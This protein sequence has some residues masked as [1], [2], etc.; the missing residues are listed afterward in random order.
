M[1][2]IFHLFNRKSTDTQKVYDALTTEEGLTNW[3]SKAT[4]VEYRVGSEIKFWFPN[5][6]FMKT[7]II[8]LDQNKSVEWECIHGDEQWIGTK[9]KF[10]IIKK[11]DSINIKFIHYDWKEK[12]EL[13]GICNYHWGLYMKSLKSLIEE[14]KGN[15]NT[16]YY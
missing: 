6:F 13:F 3:W 7:R 5:N 8:L 10:E 2:S 14:G 4:D 12:S 16:I 15:P 1:E 9:I 11:E